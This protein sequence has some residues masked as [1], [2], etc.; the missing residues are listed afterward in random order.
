MKR[1]IPCVALLFLL[2]GCG[3]KP[4]P[5][6]ARADKDPKIAAAEEKIAKTT[7]E[8]KQIIEK[9]QTMK[10]EVN[11]QLST[12]TLSEMVDDYA[13]NKGAYNI[14]PIG[15]EATQ[16]KTGRWKVMFYYQ[17]WQKQFLA[18][19]WEYDSSANKLY[20]FEK[21]NA[22]GFYSSEGAEAK[23]KKGRK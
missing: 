13:K 15:W 3:D 14:T 22:P 23:G 11:E 20:P 10:P 19:E 7:A 8:G 17:D 16:K 1:I 18:A 12:K 9:V 21:D 5:V 6:K 2:V 4:A